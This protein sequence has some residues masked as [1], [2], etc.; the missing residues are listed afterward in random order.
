MFFDGECKSELQR[1]WISDQLLNDSV[2]SLSPTC[3]HKGI[4]RFLDRKD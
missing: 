1:G 2:T 3:L 4:F